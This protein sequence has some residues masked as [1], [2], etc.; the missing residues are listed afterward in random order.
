MLRAAI[1]LILLA[2]RVRLWKRIV[3]NAHAVSQS[4]AVRNRHLDPERHGA[5]Y[6]CAGDSNAFAGCHTGGPALPDIATA[7]SVRRDYGSSRNPHFHL[8]VPEHVR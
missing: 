3:T 5:D 4:D 8:R 1:C 6:A 7:G 2:V